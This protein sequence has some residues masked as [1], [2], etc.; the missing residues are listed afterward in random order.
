MQGIIIIWLQHKKKLYQVEISHK[1]KNKNGNFV[2]I[3]G[4]RIKST[5]FKNNEDPINKFITARGNKFKVIGVL[6]EQ[7][8]F[9]WSWGR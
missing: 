4:S 7:R 5:L 6:G 9:F 3:I 1:L 2:T 8:K